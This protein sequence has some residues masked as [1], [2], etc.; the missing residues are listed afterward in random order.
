LAA[1]AASS[2]ADTLRG[3]AAGRGDEARGSGLLAGGL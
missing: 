2:R 3:V 1:W